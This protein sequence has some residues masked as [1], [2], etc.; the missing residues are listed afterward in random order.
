MIAEK[1]GRYESV[2]LYCED[3]ARFGLFTYVGKGLTARGVKPICPFQQVF[4]YTYLFGAYSP[5]NGDHFELELPFCNS[6]MF[7]RYLDEFSQHKPKELKVVVLDNGAF[8]KAK[9]LVI[10]DNIL[11]MFLPPYSPELNPAEKIWWRMKRG[12]VNRLF[13]NLDQ[14]SDYI[15]NAVIGLTKMEVISIC[16][17][18]YFKPAQ[19]HWVI[20]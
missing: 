18:D 13:D 7:Q 16:A 12:Y 14:L 5:I 9:R 4:Q 17:F 2:N 11:L 19:N 3:E 1:T 20:L 8:H 6:D 15:A 10:P